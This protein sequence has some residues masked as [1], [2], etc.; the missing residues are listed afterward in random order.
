M[1]FLTYTLAIFF[2]SCLLLTSCAKRGYITG[3]A[4]DTLAPVVLKCIPENFST[5][6]DAKEIKITFDEYIKL[7]KINQNLIISPPFNTQP[8]IIPAGAATKTITIKLLDSLKSN[9]TYSFN[10]G[11]SIADNNEGN[12]LTDFKYIFSTGSYIDSLKIKGSIKESYNFKKDNFVSVMLYDA[13]TFNDST[14]YKEKPI[15]ITN[16]LDSLTT[17]SI[18][19]IKEGS[20]YL[21]AMKDRNGNNK[22]E[23]KTEK[24]GF[25]GGPIQLPND[26]LRELVLFKEE[27]LPSVSKPSMV[28][29]NKWLVPFEGD[30]KNLE[31]EALANN[32]PIDV[33]FSKIQEKDS[34]H[35]FIPKIAYDSIQ[36]NFKNG[37]YE[38][39]FVN[40]PRKLK[41]IDSLSISFNKN[42]N[43]DFTDKIELLTST[44]VQSF[45]IKKMNLINKDSIQVPFN[46]I[47]D[48]LNLK[49]II[50]FEKLENQKYSF[51][52]LPG[53]I[54]DFYN[55]SNDSLST[56]FQTDAYTKFGNLTLTLGNTSQ[57]PLIIELLNEKEQ[58]IAFK[59]IE[60]NNPVEFPNLKPSK[61]FVRIIVDEN[62]N[63]KFDTGN[64]L[65]KQQPEK[66]YLFEKPID[67]RANWEVNETLVIPN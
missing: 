21:V 49:M 5:N 38:K 30:Y 63:G 7:N 32:R 8:E 23:P 66:V 12:I 57:F 67:V 15:Y 26:S 64:Y 3:G 25:F 14:V 29:Q 54:V 9:T 33:R 35:I 41:E 58:I 36:F 40:K 42:G 27:K 61:Y 65:L 22:F 28:S 59:I 19:N 53:A 2:V 39:S 20:Y 37:N 55:K 10:F 4:A 46:I 31:I 62:K 51:E 34:V 50:D 18:E 13:T 16:T 60:E 43:I 24:I 52:M 6:F 44:P 1:K 11:Q 17:F 45:D 48:E 47:N 56:T